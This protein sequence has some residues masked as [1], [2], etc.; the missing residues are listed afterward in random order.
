MPLDELLLLRAGD[1]TVDAKFEAFA[2]DRVTGANQL[3]DQMKD[4]IVSLKQTDSKFDDAF[5][6]G[7]FVELM[8]FC[9]SRNVNF[10][11]DV[12]ILDYVE[13][14]GYD[15]GYGECGRY[16]VFVSAVPSHASYRYKRGASHQNSVSLEHR[17]KNLD[18]A[19]DARLDAEHERKN[20]IKFGGHEDIGGSKSKAPS[21]VVIADTPKRGLTSAQL[22]NHHDTVSPRVR[23]GLVGI[24]GS[25][26]SA[27]SSWHDAQKPTSL[28]SLSCRRTLSFNGAEVDED[29]EDGDDVQACDSISNVGP[30]ESTISSTTIKQRSIKGIT[31]PD[32]SGFQIE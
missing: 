29:D 20:K 21:T 27:A 3:K 6:E 15:H 12:E 2:V 10:D 4:T 26:A 8:Q 17:H 30:Q 19:R 9:K 22:P 13:S 5:D 7:Y 23:L 24:G 1:E 11:T 28:D 31:D 14:L 18:D 25:Q 16:G 32:Y